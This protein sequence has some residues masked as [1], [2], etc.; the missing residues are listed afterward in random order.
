M[1]L[2]ISTGCLAIAGTAFAL[3]T[4]GPNLRA[5]NIV[6]AALKIFLLASSTLAVF[7]T[8]GIVM[9]V[10]FERL[11]RR[12]DARTAAARQRRRARDHCVI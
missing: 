5:R 2:A 12:P 1:A 6:E 10:L 7:T 4:I 8:L 9:S 11:F 3:R